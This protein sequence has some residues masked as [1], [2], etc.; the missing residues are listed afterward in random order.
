VNQFYGEYDFEAYRQLGWLN[1]NELLANTAA[2]SAVATQ[3]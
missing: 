3:G 2:S 1:T